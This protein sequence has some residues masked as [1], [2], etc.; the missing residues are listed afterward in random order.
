MLMSKIAAK[1][2]VITTR[3]TIPGTLAAASR[4]LTV[5]RIAGCNSSDSLS[6]GAR[7]KGLAEW[8]IPETPL[9]ASSNAPGTLISGMM[10]N[11]RWGR[12]GPLA[13]LESLG[14]MSE[15]ARYPEHCSL[16]RGIHE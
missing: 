1:E 5:P 10:A 13:L 15:I 3:E 12:R 16:R 4:T 14:W 7:T 6:L 2:D 11:V 8:M 9:A